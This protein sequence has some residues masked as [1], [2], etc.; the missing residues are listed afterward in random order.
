MGREPDDDRVATAPGVS[1]DT[2]T[3]VGP[4]SVG[5]GG[6]GRRLRWGK[7]P[8]GTEGDDDDR[9]VADDERRPPGITLVPPLRPDWWA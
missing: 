5:P 7:A 3:G 8:L 4:D 6:S 9:E 1:S 2:A